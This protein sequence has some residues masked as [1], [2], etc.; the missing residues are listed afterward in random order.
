ME[1]WN[2][3]IQEFSE[4][5]LPIYQNHEKTF[6]SYG[7]HGQLHISRSIIFSE[8]LS[9]HY[10]NVDINAVRYA[11]SFHDSGRQGNGVDIWENDSVENCFNYLYNKYNKDYAKYISSLILKDRHT[12]DINKK[13]VYD[14]DVL[15]IM[16]PCCGHGER[17]NFRFNELLSFDDI[18]FRD[19]LVEDAWKLIEYTAEN[20]HLF[21]GT[22][23]LYKLV[24]IVRKNDLGFRIL[25]I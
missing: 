22:N 23:H 7:I 8:F 11:V 13:I 21:S 2:N 3:F 9:K 20:R 17:E 12:S 14:V 1:N 4:E 10:K 5:I 25:E 6:D 24:D 18:K 15:E 19:D 16:R